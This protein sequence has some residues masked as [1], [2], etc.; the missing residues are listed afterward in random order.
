MIIEYAREK[1]NISDVEDVISFITFNIMYT[2]KKDGIFI[3][4]GEYDTIIEFDKKEYNVIV[5]VRSSFRVF[6]FSRT[7]AVDISAF[8]RKG[9]MK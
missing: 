8:I 6:D 3:L 2:D 1:Y 4:R 7:S 5:C 9:L